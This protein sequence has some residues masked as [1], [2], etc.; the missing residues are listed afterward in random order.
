MEGTI[1]NM[2]SEA[3]AFCM[4]NMKTATIIDPETGIVRGELNLPGL[5][6]AADKARLDDKDDVLNGIAWNAGKGTF[7]VTGKRWPK[8]FE[9]KVKLIPYGR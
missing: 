8:L 3:M 1:A 2:F 7:Y 4:R 6:P 9:I 5:L